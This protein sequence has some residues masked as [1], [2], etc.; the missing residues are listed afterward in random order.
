MVQK[1]QWRKEHYDTHYGA[2]IFHYLRELAI[3]FHQFIGF[4]CLDD[5]HK[6][7]NGEPGYLLAAA[8][9]GH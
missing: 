9:Y 7:K 1:C 6:I 8:E 2:A 3:K 5:E 4:V